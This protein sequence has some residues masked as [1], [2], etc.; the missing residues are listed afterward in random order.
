MTKIRSRQ[1][2]IADLLEAGIK[3]GHALPPEGARLASELGAA[4][5]G[6]S[7]ATSIIAAQTSADISQLSQTPKT[8]TPGDLRL[9]KALAVTAYFESQPNSESHI[10]LACRIES[11]IKQ[12]G[13]CRLHKVFQTAAKTRLVSATIDRALIS[14]EQLEEIVLELGLSELGSL[15]GTDYHPPGILA[16]VQFQTDEVQVDSAWSD[17]FHH[18]QAF[19]RA[20]AVSSPAPTNTGI[21]PGSFDPLHKGHLEMADFFEKRWGK[22]VHFELAIRNMDKPPLDYLTIRHR[23]SQFEGEVAWL[24]NLPSFVQKSNCFPGCV[25][26]VGADTISRIADRRYYPTATGLED[27]IDQLKRNG[28]RF[29]VFGRLARQKFC[30]LTDLEIPISLRKLCDEIPESDFRVDLSSSQIRNSNQS[31]N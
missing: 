11:A 16:S 28:C 10:G 12:P 24:T 1:R 30:A 29:L 2:F 31:I 19:C 17:V 20:D 25:F 27:A 26:L 18:R 13:L 15:A 14:G 21:L 23:L 7:K 9:A 3:V 6:E 5:S 4:C 8:G 22:K